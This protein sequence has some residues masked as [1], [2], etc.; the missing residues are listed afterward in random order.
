MN[1]GLADQ[2][3]HTDFGSNKS[4]SKFIFLAAKIIMVLKRIFIRLAHTL[5]FSNGKFNSEGFE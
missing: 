1:G 5:I 4:D 3:Q 2:S